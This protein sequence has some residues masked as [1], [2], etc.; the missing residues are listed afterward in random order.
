MLFLIGKTGSRERKLLNFKRS[1]K[2]F[3]QDTK[4]ISNYIHLLYHSDSHQEETLGSSVF[5][6]PSSNNTSTLA[7]TFQLCYNPLG[8]LQRVIKNK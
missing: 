4:D 7:L 3:T 1:S 6:K 2:T 8:I 5:P